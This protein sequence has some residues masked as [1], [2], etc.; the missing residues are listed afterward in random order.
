MIL[1]SIIGGRLFTSRSSATN[2]PARICAHHRCKTTELRPLPFYQA[3]LALVVCTALGVPVCDFCKSDFMGADLLH[4]CST[5]LA[6]L[7]NNVHFPYGQPSSRAR[8]HNV[9]CT[10]MH[11]LKRDDKP[12]SLVGSHSDFAPTSQLVLTSSYHDLG[13]P[14]N[15]SNAGS[16][17]AISP[18]A[19]SL[20]PLQAPSL[21]LSLELR[22]FAHLPRV[23]RERDI[24][25]A[26]LLP[27]YLYALN[28][29]T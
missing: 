8:Q 22:P 26:L 13:R 2:C 17:H 12:S 19:S 18:R 14:S 9:C 27:S 4:M 28:S 24:F 25:N 3:A 11:F 1:S 6:A 10:S 23:T 16:S 21:M 5:V 29:G 20:F 15:S 7:S